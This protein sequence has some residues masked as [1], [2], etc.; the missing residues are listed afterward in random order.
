L[1]KGLICQAFFIVS[2]VR[3]FPW[4]ACIAERIAEYFGRVRLTDSTEQ[5]V[6]KQ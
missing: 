3:V 4:G 2:G 6:A 1:R 5:L